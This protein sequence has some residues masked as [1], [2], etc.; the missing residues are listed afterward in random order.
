MGHFRELGEELQCLLRLKTDPVAYGRYEQK[1]D[2]DKIDGL[3]RFPH[4]FSFG[5][6]LF[7]ARFQG[8]T[9]GITAEDKMFARCMRING[10]LPVSMESMDAEAKMLATTWFASPEDGMEQ[11]KAYPRIPVAEAIVVGP[12]MKEEFEP[13]IILIFGKPAQISLLMSGMQREKYERFQFFFMG[14]GACADSLAQSYVT[15]KPAVEIPCGGERSF[16]Q[17]AD[18]E[19][20]IALPPFYF[21]RALSGLRKLRHIGIKYPT[22]SIGGIA[23]I[24]PIMK[25]VYSN[26]IEAAMRKGK[27]AE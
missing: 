26:T 17:L 22:A 6:A 14:E 20:I 16:S 24:E 10:L 2:L 21:E 15:G 19:L 13:D 27:A 4:M 7:A 5:Q 18:D 25:R 23:D 8:L 3:F 12:L 11:Q 9:V 1:D